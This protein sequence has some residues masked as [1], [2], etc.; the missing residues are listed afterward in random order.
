MATADPGSE[1]MDPDPW[2]PLTRSILAAASAALG[3]AGPS[4]APS[5]L[6]GLLTPE[7]GM[8]WDLALP[9]H[10]FAK[11][12]A[13]APAEIAT[14]VAAEFPPVAGLAEAVA[15]GPY[16]NFR[17]D[18][19]W[20]TERTLRLVFDRGDAYG[21]AARRPETVC[22]EHTS[23]NPT[24]P[25]HIGR[26]RNALIGDTLVRVL[27]AA[28]A[29][30]TTQYYVDDIGRQAAMMTWIWTKPVA[31]WPPEIRAALEGADPATEKPDHYLGRPYPRVNEYLKE[32]PEADAEVQA[33][34]HALETTGTDAAHRALITRVLDGMLA[35]LRRLGV[36]FD[37]FVW[38]SDLVADGSVAAV[39]ERLHRAPGAVQEANGAWAIDAADAGL[40]QESARI[41]F[42]RADG[43]SLYATRDVAYHL[44]KLA[45]F[46]RVVDVLGSNH[47]LHARVLKVLLQAVG[48]TRTPEVVLY[49]YITAGDG[50]GMST[51][52]GTAV[53]LDDLLEEAVERARAE[54]RRRRTD[55]AESEVDAIADSVAAGAIRYHILRVAADK[56]VAFR[57][58]EAISFEGRSGPFA[59]YSYARASSILRRAELRPGPL[60][61]RPEALGT[62]E[63]WSVVRRTSRLPGLVA[64]VARTGHVHALAGYAHGLAEEFNRFYQ[65]VPVL[66]AA[67]E[68]ESRLA[69]VAAFRQALGNCLALLGLDR[70]DRM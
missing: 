66:K 51:R 44:Q 20:L 14:R 58:D 70:L 35:S 37:T 16:L 60:P 30:V 39:I 65:E 38:E 21:H 33:L 69:L 47:L 11:P 43:S 67:G 22:V 12:L 56:T 25:F 49:Q 27:R 62:P 23:A 41:I 6:E 7:E 2:R 68:R 48:E 8:G 28:G 64:Y 17:V 4:A 63:E 1:P 29:P 31:A 34:T 61:F 18:R 9:L 15:T 42:T 26:I 52:R 46:D 53:H 5:A 3:A 45:A 19:N 50:G 54:I 32:H 59:Q 36:A 13:R 40:P 55:L 10:R 24:G 57:W